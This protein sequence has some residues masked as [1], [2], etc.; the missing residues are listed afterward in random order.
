M[1]KHTVLSNLKWTSALLYTPDTL[2]ARENWLQAGDTI[3][4]TSHTVA[5]NDA[6]MATSH[7]MPEIQNGE[8]DNN[9]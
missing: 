4:A 7:T 5:L 3:I 2:S 8:M 1:H 9:Q 6:W